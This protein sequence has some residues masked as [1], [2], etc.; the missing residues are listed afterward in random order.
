VRKAVKKAGLVSPYDKKFAG[1]YPKF[2]ALRKR[3]ARFYLEE[4]KR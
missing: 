1:K 4:A 2:L 3:F